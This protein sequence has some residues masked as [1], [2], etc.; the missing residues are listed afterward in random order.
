VEAASKHRSGWLLGDSKIYIYASRVV[1][2]EEVWDSAAN[3]KKYDS[4]TKLHRTYHVAARQLLRLVS[5]TP[6]A[7]IVELACGTGVLTHMLA[8]RVPKSVRIISTDRS[9]Q[10]IRVAR[11]NVISKNVEFIKCSA[12][13]IDLKIQGKADLA[14]CNAAFWQFDVDRA[15]AAISKILK[16]S[17]RVLFNISQQHFIDVRQHGPVLGTM[18]REEAVADGALEMHTPWTESLIRIV[19]EQ[20][21]FSLTAMKVGSVNASLNV[22]YGFLKIPAMT[23]PWFPD[24]TYQTRMRFLDRVWRRLDGKRKSAVFRTKWY[25]FE[26]TKNVHWSA[27]KPEQ[28][29]GDPR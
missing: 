2:M 6:G 25:C 18:M 20:N 15:L 21:G 27:A 13:T 1:L 12:E 26:L 14:I 16:D 10:M 11:R 9:N 4:F 23:R 17:G 3:A 5:V 29:T 24:L 19:A 28:H 7:L 8:E 22:S